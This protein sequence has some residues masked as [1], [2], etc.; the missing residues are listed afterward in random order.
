MD[1]VELREKIDEVDEKIVALYE[2]RIALSSSIALYKMENGLEI[3]D[4]KREAQKIESVRSRAQSERNRDDIGEIFRHI[5]ELSKKRQH[6]VIN[7]KGKSP[8]L[9]EKA[10]EM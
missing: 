3:F 5:M 9:K 4:A 1:L 10:D 8:V 7:E 2:E 6:E